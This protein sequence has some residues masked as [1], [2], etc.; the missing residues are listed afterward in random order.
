MLSQDAHTRRYRLGMRVLDYAYVLLDSLEI[1]R[2][3]VSHLQQLQHEITGTLSLGVLDVDEVVLVERT[4]GPWVTPGG[5][6]LGQR[7]PMYASA[8]G[9]A[10]LAHVAP[11]EAQRIIAQLTLEPHTSRTLRTRAALEQ[12][13]AE[14]RRLGYAIADEELIAGLR[15]L[16]APVRGPDG[17]AVAAISVARRTS[18]DA[19][20]DELVAECAPRLQLVAER[21]SAALGYRPLNSTGSPSGFR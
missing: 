6:E 21:I 10:I 15:S 4:F 13:L 8:T 11:S 3:A 12:R 20:L 2:I 18:L 1:R 5:F 7:L 16:A 9:L 17:A 19:S 14:T